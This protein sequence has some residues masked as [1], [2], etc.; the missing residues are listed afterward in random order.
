MNFQLFRAHINHATSNAS[1]G[2][3]VSSTGAFYKSFIGGGLLY[4]ILVK[5]ES[6]IFC[7]HIKLMRGEAEEQL[8]Y[9][10]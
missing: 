9:E 7:L 6:R 1:D 5:F 4:D 8:G 10:S 2:N 3:V